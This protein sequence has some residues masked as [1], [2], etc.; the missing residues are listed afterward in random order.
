M[1]PNH[2]HNYKDALSDFVSSC[3]QHGWTITDTRA[4]SPNEWLTVRLNCSVVDASDDPI[5]AKTSVTFLPMSDWRLGPNP[6]T[7]LSSYSKDV[8]TAAEIQW[9]LAEWQD[10][11]VAWPGKLSAAQKRIVNLLRDGHEIEVYRSF[12]INPN[13]YKS[14]GVKLS[15]AALTKLREFGV[16]SGSRLVRLPDPDPV[17]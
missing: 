16:L 4:V 3:Q 15:C 7:A 1:R 17:Q 2:L 9:L 5:V 12:G 8:S 14:N 13:T 11:F 10:R 6:F